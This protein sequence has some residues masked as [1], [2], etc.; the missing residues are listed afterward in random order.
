MRKS[1]D[2]RVFWKEEQMKNMKKLLA[3]LL[4]LVMVF[5]LCGVATA[6][7]GTRPTAR[8]E[9]TS[10]AGISSVTVGGTTAYYEYDNNTGSDVK[11]IRA[12]VPATVSLEDLQ[13]ITVVITTTGATPTVTGTAAVTPTSTSG[14][15]Y[16]YTLNLLNN[17]YSVAVSGNTYYLAAGFAGHVA[18]DENDT[19]GVH[20]VT[21]NNNT[22]NAYG[23][24]AQSYYV[25]N[26]YYLD[27]NYLWTDTATMLYYIGGSYTYQ[28]SGNTI[29]MTLSLSA[30]TS[31]VTGGCVIVNG[32]NYYY[33][34][35]AAAPTFSITNG[36]A[37]RQYSISAVLNP[38]TSFRISA[39]TYA[40]DFTELENDPN[41][42]GVFTSNIDE[43]AT[44]LAAY[45]A[46]NP[47]FSTSASV[48]DVMLA[49]I[50]FAEEE[51]LFSY[52]T[53]CSATYLSMLNGL[54]EFSAGPLSGWCYM[55][56]V[57]SPTCEVPMVGAADYPLGNAARFTWF[58]TTDYTSHF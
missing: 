31:V 18:I 20:A 12:M 44:A 36:T 45:Y 25:G 10:L 21:L 17:R 52:T 19:L 38:A 58:L 48:M 28:G 26:G 40:I 29:P 3:V 16:T 57:Y 4:T 35:G 32:T 43:I 24:V 2:N 53:S 13:A 54:G 1:K 6:E 50:D 22:V 14:N 8:T 51:G 9:V 42:G 49:F 15:A 11:Y 46:T 30:G 55:D 41:Y 37:S 39:S 7:V 34:M 27:N 5:S 23:A 47:I 56:G 33:N